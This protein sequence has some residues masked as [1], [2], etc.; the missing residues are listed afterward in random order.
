M[1]T[2]AVVSGTLS[3]KAR[4]VYVFVLC[5]TK[6][7]LKTSLRACGVGIDLG[8]RDLAVRRDG[9]VFGNSSKIFSLKN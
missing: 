5:E 8:I 7:L 3:I 6:P 9:Q 1:P 2:D 4:R